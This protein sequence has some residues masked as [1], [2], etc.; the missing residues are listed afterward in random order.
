MT[1]ASQRPGAASF[2]SAV[3]GGYNT[4]NPVTSWLEDVRAFVHDDS[5][6]RELLLSSRRSIYLSDISDAWWT[7]QKDL[8]ERARVLLQRLN[9]IVLPSLDEQDPRCPTLIRVGRTLRELRIALVSIRNGIRTLADDEP[10]LQALEEMI[11]FEYHG[12]VFDQVLCRDCGAILATSS[13]LITHFFLEHR[14]RVGEP[15]L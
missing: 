15:V 5:G 4:P 13:D 10:R 8:D 1:A 2:R 9:D 11:V 12:G 14:P 6:D 3:K 7:G